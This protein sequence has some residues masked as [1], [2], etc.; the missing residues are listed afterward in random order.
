M[1]EGTGLKRERTPEFEDGDDDKRSGTE[2]ISGH[3][4]RPS[5][6]EWLPASKIKSAKAK[7]KRKTGLYA[8][9]EVRQTHPSETMEAS[10]LNASHQ[11]LATDETKDDVD[12]QEKLANVDSTI[13]DRIRKALAL[14]QHGECNAE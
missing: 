2:D 13:L 6:S 12:L 9:V 1:A 3:D 4:D 8:S 10:T 11:S 7:H 14:A 5:D